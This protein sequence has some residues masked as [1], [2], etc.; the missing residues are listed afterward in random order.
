M[1]LLAQKFI[2][3]LRKTKYDSFHA[4]LSK[5]VSLFQKF[6]RHRNAQ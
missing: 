2:F 4:L 5:Y 3:L 1:L 6:A